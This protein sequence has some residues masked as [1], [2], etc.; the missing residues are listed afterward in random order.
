[1]RW[2][3][4]VRS[5]KVKLVLQP[6]FDRH[7]MFCFNY[8][9]RDFS[10]LFLEL[11]NFSNLFSFHFV[12]EQHHSF[13]WG[14][15]GWLISTLTF[16]SI[17]FPMSLCISMRVWMYSLGLPFLFFPSWFWAHQLAVWKGSGRSHQSLEFHFK[18]GLELFPNNYFLIEEKDK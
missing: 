14:S 12:G 11:R 18:V 9:C 8:I 5:C 15:V 2:Q 17:L 6:D 1:M 13:D 4:T 7:F 16:L 10:C 3:K